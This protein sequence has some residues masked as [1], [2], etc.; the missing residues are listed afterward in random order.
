MCV[1]VT[2]DTQD[3]ALCLVKTRVL[4]R[5]FFLLLAPSVLLLFVPVTFVFSLTHALVPSFSFSLSLFR[6]SF[7]FTE[8]DPCLSSPCTGDPRITCQKTG[9]GTYSCGCQ[10]GYEMQNGKCVEVDACAKAPCDKNGLFY[11]LSSFLVVAACCSCVYD[12]EILSPL[13]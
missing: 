2:K 13:D 1:P 4:V 12:E 5:F 11:S 9:P 8:V 6:L 3:G 10:T 7:L